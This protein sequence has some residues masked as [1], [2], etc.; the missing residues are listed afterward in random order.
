MRPLTLHLFV[1]SLFSSILATNLPQRDSQ[2]ATVSP[3]GK[4][5]YTV[6]PKSDADITQTSDFI[7][8]V[9][10]VEDLL[11]WSDVND[12]LM[13]WTVEASLD[14]VSQLQ[15]NT[16][17]DHVDEFH[18]PAPPTTTRTTRDVPAVD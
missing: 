15:R 11:P 2:S 8:Q 1:L 6:F 5:Y 18:P 13:H 3:S 12:N 9:V 4:Q 17:I 16:G 7:K 10:G 14:E